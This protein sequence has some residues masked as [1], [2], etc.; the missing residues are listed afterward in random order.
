MAPLLFVLFAIA[1]IMF[2]ASLIKPKWGTFGKRPDL[3]RKQI[4]TLYFVLAV[5]FFIAT[6]FMV[7][8]NVDTTPAAPAVKQEI[9]SNVSVKAGIGDTDTRWQKEYGDM[10]GDSPKHLTVNGSK[11]TVVFVDGRAVNINMGKR[12][13]YYENSILKDMIP[14]DSEV[15]NKEKDTSDPML[16]KEKTSYHSDTLEKAY[17]DSKGNFVVIT[18]SDAKVK[19]YLNTVI[20][21]MPSQ[22]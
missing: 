16:I 1:F 5:V 20:D 2:I 19:A 10:Q 4:S 6:C 18:I 13:K 22:S 15:V 8:E 7:P 3:K 12:D 14:A 11:T 9:P 21:C 17:P